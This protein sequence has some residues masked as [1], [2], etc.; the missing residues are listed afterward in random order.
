MPLYTYQ[1]KKCDKIFET[2][3][4]GSEKASCPACR[5]KKLDW[6]PG[7]PSPPPWSKTVVKA[8]R[9]QAFREG[10]LSNYSKSDQERLLKGKP[11]R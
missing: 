7:I 3:I 9:A 11:E 1:C 2:L 4:L 5:G 10:H 6:L 8:A